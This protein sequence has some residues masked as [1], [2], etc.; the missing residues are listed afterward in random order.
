MTSRFDT[1]HERDRQQDGQTDGQT[2]Q[3]T[4]VDG[5]RQKTVCLSEDVASCP[6]LLAIQRTDHG[7]YITVNNLFKQL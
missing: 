3:A 1:I 2:P 7:F 5:Q 4:A 6:R